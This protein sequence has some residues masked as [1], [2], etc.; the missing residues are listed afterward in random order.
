MNNIFLRPGNDEKFSVTIIDQYKETRNEYEDE[1]DCMT[2][3]LMLQAE[4]V[5]VRGTTIKK[6]NTRVDDRGKV[7]FYGF[8]I[9]ENLI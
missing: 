6:K 8:V 9:E 1:V 7:Y 2:L 4:Y 3:S 5:T